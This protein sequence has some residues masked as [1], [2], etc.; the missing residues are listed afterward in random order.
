[1]C[2]NT[3]ELCTFR[4]GMYAKFTVDIEIFFL[5][6]LWYWKSSLNVHSLLMP[7]FVCW[8]S[9]NWWIYGPWIIRLFSW[10]LA[11]L[12]YVAR[13]NRKNWGTIQ[14]R[15]QFLAFIIYFIA[16]NLAL[17]THPEYKKKDQRKDKQQIFQSLWKLDLTLYENKGRIS[18]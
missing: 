1:M 11:I 8:L 4:L 18:K 12:L 16:V 9:S 17:T 15:G 3:T 10:A 5:S 13:P 6:L 14:H 7:S 2:K